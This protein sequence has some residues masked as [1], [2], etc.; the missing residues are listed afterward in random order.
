MKRI[1]AIYPENQNAVE[2]MLRKAELAYY[3]WQNYLKKV[4]SDLDSDKDG[5]TVNFVK[6][7]SYKSEYEATVSCIS[8]LAEEDKFAIMDFIEENVKGWQDEDEED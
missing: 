1:Y 3:R 4:W 8:F 7:A 2:R 5:Y 6:A